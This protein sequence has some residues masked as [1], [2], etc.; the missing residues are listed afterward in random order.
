MQDGHQQFYGS[1]G[2]NICAVG[3]ES[4]KWCMYM[5]PLL[6]HTGLCMVELA[7]WNDVLF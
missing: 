7:M 4:E 5:V 2:N 3:G 1:K 6:V